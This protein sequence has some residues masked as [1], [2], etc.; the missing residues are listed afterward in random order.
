MVDSEHFAREHG[1]DG[2]I[3]EVH[4]EPDRALSDGAQSLDPGQFDQLMSEVRHIAPFL[5]RG[6]PSP[7]EVAPADARA[8]TRALAAELAPYC[9][10][11]DEG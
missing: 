6:V 11:V 4:P 5:R 8:F 10:N 9:L 7:M 2:L 1:C 3:V